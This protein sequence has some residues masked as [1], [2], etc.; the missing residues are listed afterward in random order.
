M[1]DD[2]KKIIELLTSKDGKNII[3]AKQLSV[4][5]NL[6][7]H[8][9]LITAMHL[10]LFGSTTSFSCKK[11]YLNEC[12]FKVSSD[13][14]SNVRIFRKFLKFCGF[15]NVKINTAHSK[16]K[17]MSWR[18]IKIKLEVDIPE[19][20]VHDKFAGQIYELWNSQDEKTWEQITN[21][22]YK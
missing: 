7:F 22:K 13:D 1:E 18:Y 2:T 6:N 14:L 16:T 12:K 4:S 10:G 17:L 21:L 19:W 20:E 5:Q 3:L 8:I 9:I 15:Y 11:R